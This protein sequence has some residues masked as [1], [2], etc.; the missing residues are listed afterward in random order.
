MKSEGL[1]PCNDPI[2]SGQNRN[3]VDSLYLI[4]G[5]GVH[6]CMKHNSKRLSILRIAIKAM[7]QKR[8]DLNFDNTKI[9]HFGDHM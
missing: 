9:L 8:D 1:K 3:D 5:L 6:A 2:Q 7:C 4:I